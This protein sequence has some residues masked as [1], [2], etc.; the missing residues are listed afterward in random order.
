MKV[1]L[2]LIFIIGTFA[3][4]IACSSNRFDYIVKPTPLVKGKTGYSVKNVKVKIE[5]FGIKFTKDKEVK[6]Y[7]SEDDMAKVF[8][9]KITEQLK[10]NNIFNSNSEYTI[11]LTINYT[12]NFAVN[13]TKVLHPDYSYEWVIEKGGSPVAR[14]KS[15]EMT[16]SGLSL[17]SEV[18]N[19]GSS[20]INPEY[21]LKFIELISQSIVENTIVDVG[22]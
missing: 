4:F 18:L 16:F 22:K 5:I 21:E 13:S 17:F 20:D 1:F 11:L 2:R 12:R 10:K 19:T 6:G 9:E 3:L 14:Y 15:P 8:N 7:L